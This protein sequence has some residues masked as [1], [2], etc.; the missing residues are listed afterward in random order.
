MSCFP[1]DLY[2]LEYVFQVIF[3]INSLMI[4][5]GVLSPPTGVPLAWSQNFHIFFDFMILCAYNERQN[6]YSDFFVTITLKILNYCSEFPEITINCSRNGARCIVILSIRSGAFSWS[7]F[8]KFY[9]FDFWV[10][11]IKINF[12]INESMGFMAYSPGADQHYVYCK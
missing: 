4:V 6:F 2:S 7:N 10:C 12:P 8:S 11:C 9:F 1:P 5:L 3:I